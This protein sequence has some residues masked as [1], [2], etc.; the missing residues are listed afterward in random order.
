MYFR[1]LTIKW[2]SLLLLLFLLAIIQS[3]LQ[4]TIRASWRQALQ[5]ST[6][7][8]ILTRFFKYFTRLLQHAQNAGVLS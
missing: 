3:P 7:A 2:I 1:V 5:L 8:P 4:H 6:A